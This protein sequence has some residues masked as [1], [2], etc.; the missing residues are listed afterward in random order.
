[1]Q[2]VNRSH[3]VYRWLMFKLCAVSVQCALHN[4]PYM[5]SR[6]SHHHFSR[7]AYRHKP[8]IGYSAGVLLLGKY[9]LLTLTAYNQ[10]DHS[11]STMIFNDFSMTKNEFP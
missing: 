11:F 8:L 2:C 3:K 9:G 6:N 1:M 5:H 4:S 7:V 10:G